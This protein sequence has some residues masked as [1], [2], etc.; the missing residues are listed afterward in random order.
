MAQREAW[1][2]SVNWEVVYLVGTDLRTVEMVLRWAPKMVCP[3][4]MLRAPANAST[5]WPRSNTRL[6]P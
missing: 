2:D 6:D 4:R 1:P 5:S 3:V